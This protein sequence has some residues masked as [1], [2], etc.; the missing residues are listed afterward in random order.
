MSAL[1]LPH[2]RGAISIIREAI[3]ASNIEIAALTWST[4]NWLA[5]CAWQVLCDSVGGKELASMLITKSRF[6]TGPLDNAFCTLMMDERDRRKVIIRTC[7]QKYWSFARADRDVFPRAAAV[8]KGIPFAPNAVKRSM[9]P[10][11]VPWNFRPMPKR[12]PY[13]ELPRAPIR[14]RRVLFPGPAQRDIAPVQRD[15]VPTPE[16]AQHGVTPEPAQRDTEPTPAPET[17]VFEPLLSPVQPPYLSFGELALPLTPRS[18]VTPIRLLFD[19]E[20]FDDCFL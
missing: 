2:V 10:P 5:P 18:P 14:L 11:P 6:Y 20:L 9:N 1:S 13:A 16:P 19:D 15:V 8:Q 7:M 12:I 17:P 4:V 3:L